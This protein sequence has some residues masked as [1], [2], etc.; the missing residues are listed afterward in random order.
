[1]LASVN[2]HLSIVRSLLEE[3]A[4]AEASTDDGQTA[5]TLAR[6]YNREQVVELLKKRG[7]D[8]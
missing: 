2:G 8:L 7:G 5:L 6:E 1:M 3:G 4:A